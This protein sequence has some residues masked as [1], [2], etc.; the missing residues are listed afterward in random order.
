MGILRLRLEGIQTDAPVGRARVQALA[1]S[2]TAR[3]VA[4]RDGGFRREPFGF[5]CTMWVD[6]VEVKLPSLNDHLAFGEAEE[7]RAGQQFVARLAVEAFAAAALPGATGLNVGRLRANGGDARGAAVGTTRHSAING[8][9]SIVFVG[10]SVPPL[11]ISAGLARR[12]PPSQL[13]TEA[14]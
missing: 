8:R 10:P 7:Y 14:S 13:D 2:P 12:S 9:V 6:G 4:A 1:R 3:C 11:A 5:Q